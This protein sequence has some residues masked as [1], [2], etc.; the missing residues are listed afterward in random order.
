M[1]Y[2]RK[3]PVQSSGFTLMELMVV[4]AI[5]GILV[6]A[7]TSVFS[8]S[9]RRGRD[10]R[11]KSDLKNI[12]TVL[13]T[14]YNDKARYPNDNGSGGIMGC[15]S[16]DNQLC[17]VGSAF[18]DTN[19][20]LY[21]PKIP[22]DPKSGQIYFYDVGGGNRSFQIYARLENTEDID[23]KNPSTGNPQVFS[24]VSCGTGT[25]NYGLSSTNTTADSGRTVIDDPN[26]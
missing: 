17:A 11:R 6:V 9:Q 19:S 7:G 18:T 21:M 20:T 3:N 13:E 4:I 25:C 22:A 24:G 14:Y 12:A 1:N 2:Y 26:P 8:V 16:G 15:G 5:L 10:S 23:I